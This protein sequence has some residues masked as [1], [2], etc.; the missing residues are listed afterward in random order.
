MPYN[1]RVL[2]I[3]DDQDILKV[4]V[5]VLVGGRQQQGAG[6]LAELNEL[7]GTEESVARHHHGGFVLDTA[8]QGE[9]G[10]RLVERALVEKKPYSVAFV[11]MRMPPGW[12]GVKTAREIRRIDPYIQI[13]IVTAFSDASV[14]EIVQQVGFTDRLLYLKKPFDEEE[15][16]QLAD[17]LSMRWNLEKKGRSLIDILERVFSSFVDCDFLTKDGAIS[18]FLPELLQLLSDFLDTPDI[19]LARIDRGEVI[20]QV[21]LG[22]FENGVTQSPVFQQVLEKVQDAGMRTEVLEIDDFIVMPFICHSSPN[23]M[24]G[25]MS[26]RRIEGLAGLLKEL[27]KYTAKMLNCETQV[28]QLRKQ[29]E[30]ARQREKELQ[31]RLRQLAPEHTGKLE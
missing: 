9:Q 23:V 13:I 1:N 8:G 2:V 7:L 26:E 3:D 31:M 29:L 24:V 16:L 15:I 21:G 30:E 22:R 14:S 12:N 5:E 17:S 25:L 10:V 18:T 27:A 28:G 4:F 20:F 6:H 11:D 19:F